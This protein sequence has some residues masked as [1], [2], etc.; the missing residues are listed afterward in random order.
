MWVR[1]AITAGLLCSVLGKILDPCSITEVTQTSSVLYPDC[2][3]HQGATHGL[4]EQDG[5]NITFETPFK[6]FGEPKSSVLAY[7]NGVLSF[8]PLGKPDYLPLVENISLI[9][10]YWTDE[11][12]ALY[13]KTSCGVTSNEF[14]L[15]R[16]GLDLTSALG[17]TSYYPHWGFLCTWERVQ[18]GKAGNESSPAVQSAF[19][20]ALTSDGNYSF[21]IF[22]YV[23]VGDETANRKL[24]PVQAGVDAGDGMTFCSLKGSGK[25]R[26]HRS[27]QS[28]NVGEVGRWIFRVDA[29]DLRVPGCISLDPK[30]FLNPPMSV[31]SRNLRRRKSRKKKKGK[32]RRRKR[33]IRE[34][35]QTHS[36]QRIVKLR[37]EMTD[38][39][40]RVDTMSK[41]E[42][43]TQS[44]MTEINRRL[45]RLRSQVSRLKHELRSLTHAISQ[46]DREMGR[47]SQTTD[48]SMLRKRMQDI[49]QDI[50]TTDRQL[51]QFLARIRDFEHRLSNFDVRR[52]Q[53]GQGIM[54]GINQDIVGLGNE[55]TKS[56]QHVQSLERYLVN[57]ISQHFQTTSDNAYMWKYRS[58][59]RD[60]YRKIKSISQQML[61]TRHS[62][63]LVDYRLK[64]TDRELKRLKRIEGV[65]NDYLQKY[66][67]Q[68]SLLQNDMGRATH[69]PVEV[70]H[71]MTN[72]DRQLEAE[73]QKLQEISNK[74]RSQSHLASGLRR[75][76][77]RFENQMGYIRDHVQKL[78]TQVFAQQGK[79][80]STGR[81]INAVRQTL[82]QL[83]SK[84]RNGN[85]PQQQRERDMAFLSENLAKSRSQLRLAERQLESVYRYL[86]L[87]GRQMTQT[88]EYLQT[89][90]RYYMQYM[91][92]RDYYGRPTSTNNVSER[93]GQLSRVLFDLSRDLK[94]ATK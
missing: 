44:F 38:L 62:A 24:P 53:T 56:M 9:A 37:Q 82:T 83:H 29:I 73:Q 72:F 21:V 11:S 65:M 6:F 20:A 7:D 57:A 10:P 46:L 12:S 68:H 23:G 33:Q 94:R 47:L 93:L 64:R 39:Q 55:L 92:R 77:P 14:L 31:V 54:F 28:S 36:Y 80:S 18:D 50:M 3:D 45:P 26:I 89:L 78:S 58:L 41:G 81:F 43:A 25:R 27:L 48:D 4:V 51:S 52:E 17:V 84:L 71:T 8:A 60:R 2:I 69:T 22:N 16:L 85:R 74:L 30:K 19:Q 70:M 91:R 63:R 40:G 75:D 35:T 32:S 42:Q 5:L 87:I 61:G 66:N 88:A 59:E 76:I 79:L 34:F 49:S 1:L 67:R 86:Q 90:S 15:E 13:R